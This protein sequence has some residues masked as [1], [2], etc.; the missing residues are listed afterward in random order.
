MQV[1]ADTFVPVDVGEWWFGSDLCPACDARALHLVVNLGPAQWLCGNCGRC[2]TPA[3][4]H[5]ERV[6]PWTCAGCASNNRH[7]CIALL[8]CDIPTARYQHLTPHDESSVGITE[9]DCELPAKITRAQQR[10]AVQADCTPDQA[11][12][13]MREHA[14]TTHHRVA[15]IAD[16]VLA[17]RL[18]FSV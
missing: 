9:V 14:R 7:D 8:Q 18:W 1:F 4:G 3:D 17:H 11:L 5:L 15:D 16:A 6:D 2:W 13:L 12:V 10:I